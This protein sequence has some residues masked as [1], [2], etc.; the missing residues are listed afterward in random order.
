MKQKKILFALLA[1]ALISSLALGGC[2]KKAKVV[3]LKVMNYQQADQAGYKED[4]KIWEDF[5]KANPDIK[6]D[7]EVLFNDPYHEKLQ[8]YAAA[9]TLPDVFYVWPGSRSAV[10]HEKKLAKDL[11]VI[12]GTE[13]LK[14][15]SAAATNPANQLG[16]YMAMLPQAY[17]YTSVMYVNKKLLA[18]NGFEVPKTYAELKAMV[19]KLKAKGIA[20]VM[21]PNKDGWPMQ[22]CLFSTV[23]GRVAG[24]AFLRDVK[25]GKAK[26]TDKP[27]VDSLAVIESLYKDGIIAREDNQVGY[28]EAAGIFASGKAAIYVDGD[29]RAAA[30][31]TDKS[32]G[33]A[34][35]DPKA[36][37]SDFVLAPF[38]SIPGEQNPGVV[39]AVAGCGWS[40]NG[41]LKAGSPEEQ[42]AVRLVKYLYSPEVQAI[43]FATGQYVPTR[44]GVKADVEPLVA[45]V[46]AFYA[47][48]DKTC[49]VV[50]G[51]FD[52]A[53]Y[54]VLN[55]GLIAIG[56]GT[57]KPAAVAAEIQKAFDA[58][59][60]AAK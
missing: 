53:V 32:S 30:Y 56:L 7:M 60:A 57:K 25:A 29:W 34:L 49:Y 22:S 19:P 44:K 11:G 37:E 54:N 23:A 33:K 42:A 6:L 55:S 47:E 26:F 45:K 1:A 35:I 36:Q 15:F 3:T 31:I 20:A 27:F 59:K 4:V 21:L 51:V 18:D 41:A 2:A 40:I 38:V 12:L 16:M 48:N 28:G 14:D 17:T 24:D 10:I 8:A 9:G 46:P 13:Y 50:D 58:W 39:S 52:P 43:R 5:Q